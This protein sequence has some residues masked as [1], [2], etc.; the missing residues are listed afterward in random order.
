M[1]RKNKSVCHARAVPVNLVGGNQTFNGQ[2]NGLTDG[3]YQ[4][5][6]TER[7]QH[8]SPTAGGKPS[9]F[10]HGLNKFT[11]MKN[12]SDYKQIQS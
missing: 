8:D 9:T 10:A 7:R 5:D 12:A 3:L 11:Q 6:A 2:K 4:N 1:K